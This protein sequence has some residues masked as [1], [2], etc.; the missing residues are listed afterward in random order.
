[1]ASS[2]ASTARFSVGNETPV[3]G[4]VSYDQNGRPIQ[5]VSY[6]PSGVIFDLKPQVRL[7]G[8]DLKL[9]QQ[10]SQFVKTTNGVNGSPTLI[11]RELT[12]DVTAS[13]DEIV[14]IGGLEEDRA[15]T[16]DTGLSFLPAFLR[17]TFD[18]TQRT[19]VVLML[20]MQRI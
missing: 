1:M 10:I 11:K 20:H 17:S 2:R 8:V 16:N 14:V 18:E 13:D 4:S 5:S 9:S 7:G 6:K 12:T 15:T 19:E 3:L